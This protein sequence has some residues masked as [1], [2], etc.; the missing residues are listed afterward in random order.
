[1]KTATING[2]EYKFM[3]NANTVELFYQVFGVD[4]LLEISLA[5][6][7]LKKIQSGTDED[8][9]KAA[10]IFLKNNRIAKLA[11]ITNM[12]TEKSISELSN[13]LSMVDFM[14]WQNAFP[15]GT[16]YTNTDVITAIVSGWAEGMTTSTE[17][18]NQ[19]GQQ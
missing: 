2:K 17:V 15:L 11:F 3:F 5:G 10:T 1:M 7:D 18:K 19:V 6:A 12:Q 4:L 8:K 13:R 9:L 16:F 14:N